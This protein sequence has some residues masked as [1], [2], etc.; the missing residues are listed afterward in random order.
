MKLQVSA[1]ALAILAGAAP[2]H[3]WAQ[4]AS[5]AATSTDATAVTGVIVTGT[6][7]TGLKAADS[8]AP[9][10][11]IGGP[12]LAKTGQPNL[13]DALNT[14][15]PAFQAQSFGNDTSN[16]SLSARLRGLNPNQVLVLVNGKRRHGTANLHVAAGAFQG[17]ASPDLSLI[18]LSA[19]D[20]IEV[21]EDGAAAQYGT[22]AIAGVINII[23][24]KSD[25][26]GELAA[27]AGQYYQ[28]DGQTGEVGGNAG[29]RLFSHGYLNLTA[30]ARTHDFSDRGAPD[31]RVLGVAALQSVPGYP[32]L[33][34]IEGDARYNQ[35]D[36]AFNAG[37]E[38]GRGV[39]LY[40]FGTYAHRN[41][42]SFENY[43]L[44][45]ILPGVWPQ[46]FS[47]LE[48]LK[49]DDLSLAVGLKGTVLDGWA[50]DLSSVYGRDW[51]RIGTTN[52]GNT[53]LFAATG[54]TPTDFHDGDFIGSQLTTTL[55]VSRPFDVGLAGPLNVAF[56]VEQRHET[57]KIDPGDPASYYGTGAQSYPGFQPVVNAGEHGRDNVGVYADLALTP[58]SKLKLDGAAR[59]ENYS[60]F[61]DAA[62]GKFTARY[63][64]TGSF[65]LR[66]TVSNGFR[67]PTLAEE[68][69]SALN[70]R[71]NGQ[72]VQ[73]P[74]DSAAARL[75]GI[76]PLKP[77]K[78]K[79]LTLGLV[80][81]P[82]GRLNLTVDAYQIEID[83]RIVA[84]GTIYGKDANV[85]LP[86]AQAQAVLAAIAAQK[87]TLDPSLPYAGVSTFTN[88]LNTRTQGVAVTATLPTRLGDLGRIDWT[89]S[90][91]FNRTKITHI[92]PP[93][94]ALAGTSL[95]SPT[96]LSDLETASPRLKI[97]GGGVW[98]RGRWDVDLRETLYGP[99]SELG[100]G[101]GGASYIEN[102][103]GVN[104]I[105]DLEV[106]W[107]VLDQ[108]KISF[109]AKNL[110]DV[111]PNRVNPA[112]VGSP[113]VGLYPGFSPF[114]FDGGYYYTRLRYA[115]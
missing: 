5:P 90:A 106:G 110:F 38:L 27:T 25:H 78:S 73:L 68:Y 69:Y 108:V 59:F 94:A 8:P 58:L 101:N 109:G 13:L 79:N 22:D 42:A 100:S 99:S 53:S 6:R 93:P 1:S 2:P 15:L 75:L 61:G 39:E 60:D 33:N 62:V 44:P 85:A 115:F 28:R 11:V 47:P 48:T 74:A 112:S 18:P 103:I 89:L 107:R 64:I 41:G 20:H 87:V 56:G 92:N 76:E 46:G 23:L 21:L 54:T 17:G 97:V 70:S 37:A 77:E 81:N 66:G 19:I 80:A 16:F 51:N 45:S 55:D 71:P 36:T 111:Y 88:G 114:G 34:H 72:Y 83:N 98:S 102:R 63:D 82:F 113:Y 86:P 35:F 24:K 84:T 29:F 52:S 40:A 4:P 65:A 104:L 14:L 12:A 105:T 95:Y 30:E 96:S 43:R 67:A 3:A 7:V 91:D 26:G 57:Y 49:E 32:H 10:V 50:W 31:S 9:V